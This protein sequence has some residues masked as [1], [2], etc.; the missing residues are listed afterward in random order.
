[1]VNEVDSKFTMERSRSRS[2]EEEN[3][4]VCSTKK[5]KDSHCAIDERRSMH[6]GEPSYPPKLSLKD[7]LVGEIP[8]AY[9]QAFAF[10]DQMEADSDLNEE[11]EEIREGFAS[12]CLPKE[13]KQCIQA[14]WTNALIIKVFGKNMGYNY[15]H[16]K[17]LELWKPNGRVDM[18]DLGRD[19]FL[20]RFSVD[21]DL[22]VV[23][24]KR[25]LVCWGPFPI[26]SEIGSELQA[27]ES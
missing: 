5:V 19:F 7:K 4:L 23:L 8:G 21:E 22:E 10:T 20:L 15:L 11:I 27:I 14:P 12:V 3:E 9:S 18:V 2:L 24:K 26:H 16:S 13:T 6:D 25:T 1:M 17:L